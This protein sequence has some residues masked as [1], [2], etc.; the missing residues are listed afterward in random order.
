MRAAGSGRI[1][2]AVEYLSGIRESA[3]FCTHVA[4]CFAAEALPVSWSCSES[5]FS[6]MSELLN[7]CA[8]PRKNGRVA[9]KGMI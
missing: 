3:P 9:E 6:M 5:R 1:Q 2:Q 8:D 4:P 7:G